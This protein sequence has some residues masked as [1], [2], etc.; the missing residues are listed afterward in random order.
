MKCPK[1]GEEI[2][3]GYLYCES[4]GE[5][6]H[7]V[8]DFEPEIEYS[9]RETLSGIVE[10]VREQIPNGEQEGMRR[11]REKR[12]WLFLV[13]SGIT[14]VVLAAAG[15]LLLQQLRYHSIEYQLTKAAACFQ[16]GNLEQAVKYYERAHELDENN[17]S[18]CFTLADLYRECGRNGQYMEL[19]FSVI[20]SETVTEDEKAAAYKRMIAYYSALEDYASINTI[21]MNTEDTSIRMMFQSYMAL[22]PEFSYQEGAYDS[23]IPLKL[24]AGTQGTIYYTTDGTVPTTESEEY[25]TPI[26]LEEGSYTV[27]AMFVNSY[28]ISSQVVAKSYFIDVAKPSAPEVETYSG[29]YSSP[30]LIRV[31]LPM[32]GEVYYTTDGTLPTEHSLLYTEP[33][34]MPLGKSVFTFITYNEDGLCGECTTREFELKLDTEYTPEQAVAELVTGLVETGRL[35]DVSGVPSGDLS[36][37]YLYQYQYVLAIPEQGD[38]YLVAEVF[39]DSAGVQSRTGTIYGVDVYSLACY[40]LTKGALDEYILEAVQ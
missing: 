18:L 24:T 28:G 21:L 15:I 32:D 29:E 6:I 9:M 13:L 39:E 5:D 11:L 34:P 12:K 36:G 38:F 23:V 10:E 8:P 26:F 4:C 16:T 22:P 2:R 20:R 37:R 40:K 30:V 1:C 25:I 17:I 31:K 7:M 3:E 27:S 35:K 33:I 19:L 14:L